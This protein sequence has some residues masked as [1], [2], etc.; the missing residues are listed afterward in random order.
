MIKKFLFLKASAK[1]LRQRAAGLAVDTAFLEE[2]SLDES[3]KN[4]EEEQLA[5]E[6]LYNTQLAKE[7]KVRYSF[8]V[9]TQIPNLFWWQGI[10]KKLNIDLYSLVLV[11]TVFLEI[12]QLVRALILEQNILLLPIILEHVTF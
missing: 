8:L 9:F 4:P 6:K 5:A 1:A 7:I 10:S 11:R 12:C 2:K 3:L